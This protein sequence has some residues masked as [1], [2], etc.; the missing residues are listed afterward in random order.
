VGG[1]RVWGSCVWVSCVWGSCV[2][3]SCVCTSCVWV[4]CVWTSRLWTSYW[5]SCVGGGSGRSGGRSKRG[6][7][8]LKTRTP[9]KDVIKMLGK[10]WYI[11]TQM[12]VLLSVCS[13]TKTKHH[14]FPSKFYK[15]LSNFAKFSSWT[16]PIPEVI[17][18]RAVVMRGEFHPVTMHLLTVLNPAA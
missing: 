15:H 8:Q 14:V 11:D 13:P 16:W 6:S 9:H 3:T 18:A 17:A 5:A 12:C 7:V 4:S 10:N 2:W 1:R